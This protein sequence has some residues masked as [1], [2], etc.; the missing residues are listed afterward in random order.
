[1]K[2][3]GAIGTDALRH[4]W[5]NLGN[6]YICPPWTSIDRVQARLKLEKLEATII[7]RHWTSNIRFPTLTQMAID[8]PTQVPR[9]M[10]HPAPGSAS[11]L[12]SKNPHWSMAAWRV[13][14]SK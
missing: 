3:E 9:N 7:V 10:V 1:M 13:S 8:N 5:K 14:G 4:T 2:E 6:L 11:D 12:L